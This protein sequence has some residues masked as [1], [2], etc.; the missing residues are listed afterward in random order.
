MLPRV[1][2]FMSLWYHYHTSNSRNVWESMGKLC[3]CM[4]FIKSSIFLLQDTWESVSGTASHA[5]CV[6]TCNEIKGSYD[7]II[8]TTV[9][10]YTRLLPL[11]LLLV[12]RT[13]NNTDG[14]KLVIFSSVKL[15]YGDNY[16]LIYPCREEL[17]GPSHVAVYR[18]ITRYI[19]Q[20]HL[21][22]LWFVKIHTLMALHK[23]KPEYLNWPL[24]TVWTRN[25]QLLDSL[26]CMQLSRQTRM[27]PNPCLYQIIPW[28]TCI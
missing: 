14:N 15:Y 7:K 24:S 17:K 8:I 16:I 25:P 20:S 27:L 9:P 19:G 26:N 2:T 11:A 10:S 28:F 22:M 3:S 1:H 5:C 21:Y 12:L 6:W 18:C 23:G 13:H 4:Q